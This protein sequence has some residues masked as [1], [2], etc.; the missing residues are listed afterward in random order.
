MS[1][2]LMIKSKFPVYF[3][4]VSFVCHSPSSLPFLS[5][6]FPRIIIIPHRWRMYIYIIRFEKSGVYNRYVL[7]LYLCYAIEM[8][9]S[10]LSDA[11]GF[12]TRKIRDKKE[13]YVINI[14]SMSSINDI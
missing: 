10:G 14:Y 5:L 2:L 8:L 13:K 7:V 6:P 11:I 1:I 3:F 12:L 9:S 4:A